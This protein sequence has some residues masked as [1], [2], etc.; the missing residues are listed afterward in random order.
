MKRFVKIFICFILIVCGI[1][2][3]CVNENSNLSQ[4]LSPIKLTDERRLEDASIKMAIGENMLATYSITPV[5]FDY[6][7]LNKRG[8]AMNITVSY[9]VKYVKTY[10]I[11]FDI[12]YAGP[13]K[14]EFTVL[15][16]NLMGTMEAN[17]TT[18]T[19]LTQ[20]SHSFAAHIVDLQGE[21]LTLT[22]STD[23]VQNTIY[24]KNIVVSYQCVKI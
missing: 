6:E 9:Q 7:E 12:G 3:G 21:T 2:S 19:S 16:T 11:P 17:L 24:F 14:Y 4:I 22:F 8:Y 1:L 5:G 20:R 15:G 13:P 18:T 10:K 23:N